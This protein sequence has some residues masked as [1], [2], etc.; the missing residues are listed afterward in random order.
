LKP[1][2]F[3]LVVALVLAVYA[4][5]G[6]DTLRV[7]K[8]FKRIKAGPYIQYFKTSDPLTV[9]SAVKVFADNLTEIKRLDAS[10][11]G[12]VK[13]DFWFSLIIKNTSTAERSL[14]LEL[15]HAHLV[16]VTFFENMNGD[17]KEWGPMGM[18][19]LF[20]QRPIKHRH[21][22][23]PINCRGGQA[24]QV[25][26]RIVHENS[27]D[28]PFIL[29][30]EGVFHTRDYEL[31]LWFGVFF[32]V[33]IFCSLLALFCF[34]MVKQ[35]VFLW[36]FFYVFTAGAYMFYDIGAAFQFIYPTITYIDA[37]IGIQLPVLMFI[38]LI[39]FSQSFLKTSVNYKTTH[40]ILNALIVFFLVMI[41][42]VNGFLFSISLWF[43]PVL[44]LI[45]LVGLLI[46]IYTGI[47]SVKTNFT[48]AIL[49]LTATGSVILSGV[50]HILAQ[51]LGLLSPEFNPLFVGILVE[52]GLLS[53]ALIL[54]YGEA[55]RERTWLQNE[56]V[57]Q[58]SKMFQQYI[59]GIEKE[60][61]RIAGDL[62]DNIGS[63]LSDIKR[64]YFNNENDEGTI[65]ITSLIEEVRHL[66]HDLAPT[67]AKV[68]GLM[69]MVEKL[70]MEA[71]GNSNVDI[72]LQTFEFKEVLPVESIIQVYR[73]I[74]EAL[75]N[76]ILHSNAKRAD[77]QFFGY[78]N[79]IVITIEDE[80]V[81]FNV[82]T[83]SGFGIN[84]IRTRAALLKSR[85]E[86]SSTPGK[87]CM[88]VL[89]IP[90]TKNP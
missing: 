87:G 33:L 60:R 10:H 23:F 85:I 55:Q 31:N 26:V 41:V 39:K 24:V 77:I 89:E 75:H 25:L 49:Y 3:F 11:L 13:D 30:D 37:P 44:F 22:V 1:F 67:I 21:F 48:S 36:Y 79:E 56:L 73:I 72:K 81:G 9:D 45:M 88:I 66:S 51:S 35:K 18:F 84:S 5:R 69:P 29:W 42:T 59:E 57:E 47:R 83:Q 20:A 38:F 86:I 27:L 74:Q 12:V 14:I 4:A 46:L 64:T 52:V 28:A 82:S 40:F 7:D 19:Y 70:I 65:R 2:H 8:Q 16:G 17:F 32:G 62:H 61:N 90:I 76:I 58:K 68:S 80:G 34:A 71:R 43:L 6:Q 15:N 53:S 54:Q 63:K 50:Y 78:E